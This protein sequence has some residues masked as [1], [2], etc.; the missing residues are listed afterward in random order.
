MQTYLFLAFLHCES[1]HSAL[2][3]SFLTLVFRFC[4]LNQ[5]HFCSALEIFQIR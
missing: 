1:R 5:L 2:L 4:F 3:F